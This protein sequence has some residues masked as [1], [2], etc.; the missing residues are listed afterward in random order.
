MKPKRNKGLSQGDK[1]PRTL[2]YSYKVFYPALRSN[3]EYGWVKHRNK[4][5]SFI[6]DVLFNIKMY[7]NREKVIEK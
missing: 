2:K 5:Y 7:S 1:K 4:S 6:S 3:K